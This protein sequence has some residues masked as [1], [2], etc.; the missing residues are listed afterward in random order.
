M[1]KSVFRILI[2]SII[3]V[4]SVSA[5]QKDGTPVDNLPSYVKRLTQFGERAD[6]SH[7]GTK[8][9][10]VEKTYGDVYE[11]EIATGKIFLRTNHFYHGG[12]TR[13][14]YLANGDIILSGSTSFDAANPQINRDVNAEL[15]VLDKSFT[16]PPVR[17]DTKCFE[18]P[19]VSRKNMKIAW[20]II[21]K[22]YPDLLKPGQHLIY[23]ADIA[24]ENGVP[25]LINKKLLIDNLKISYL[26]SIETQNFVPPLENK[27][28]FSGYGYNA[29]DVMLFNIET[30]EI[31]NMSNAPKQYDEPEGIFPDGKYTLVESDKQNM[32]GSGHVDMWKLKLD[33]S[34][35]MERLT[36]FSDYKNF[37]A[38]NAVISDDGKFMAFQMARSTDPAGVGYGIF[39]MNLTKAKK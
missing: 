26:K 5:Q 29:T 8:I 32:L 6:F 35:E 27:M 9:L 2:I 19:A 1:Y 16:K 39:N 21:D 22:Q 31:T 11:V 14:L 15:W 18:G 10:F 17:L 33:G 3:Y 23:M 38:S 30:G 28:T 13:A 7:D 12:F 37:K 34:G 25:K 36:F 4:T 24:Y 20:T